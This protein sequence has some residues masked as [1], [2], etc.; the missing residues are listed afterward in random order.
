MSGESA[1]RKGKRAP[2]PG[3]PA[4]GVTIKDL[5]AAERPRERLLA[6][7]AEALSNGELLAILLGTGHQAGGASALDLALRILRLAGRR[8]PGIVGLASLRPEELARIPGVGLAKAAR[9]VAALEL[10][11]R[12]AVTLPLGQALK[13]PGD[14]ARLLGETMRRLQREH[15]KVLL[16]NTKNQVLATETIS[17]GTLDQTTVHPREVFRS[18]ISRGA[19]AVILAHNHP[20]GDPTPS[21]DDLA[22]TRRLIEGGRLMGIPVLDHVIIGDGRH[23]SVREL[24]PGWFD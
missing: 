22:V 2:A 20:S 10:G 21:P 7:G 24:H 18:A 6:Q 11:R 13:G 16:V 8:G 5:P 12:M 17:I 23:T 19:A 1:R 14:V 3:S 4:G 15:F 9:V